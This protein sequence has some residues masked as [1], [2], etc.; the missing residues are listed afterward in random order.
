MSISTK[1][2]SDQMLARFSQISEEIQLRQT[3]ISTG[4]E[5]TEAAEK[6]LEAVKLSALE[7]GLTQLGG[8][9]KNVGVAQSRLS[10][11]DSVL[12]SVDEYFVRLRE[13]S[14]S[15][16]NDTKSASDKVALKIEVSSIREALIGLANTQTSGGEALF[17][18]YATDIVPF[19][20]DSNGLIK[21]RG[22]G[23]QHT[24]AAS[25][26]MRLP[27]SIN[28]GR[29]FMNVETVDG[30]ASIFDIVDSFEAALATDASTN[31][32]LSSEAGKGLSLS[33]NGD[34]T[35]RDLSFTLEGTGGSKLITASEVVGGSNVRLIEAINNHTVNTG[36]AATSVDG[37]LVL[38][39][40]NN[41]KIELSNLDIE[42]VTLASRTPQFTITTNDVPSKTMVP[43]VQSLSVHLDKIIK[44]GE[45]IAISRTTVGARLQ[46]ANDQET[47]IRT[48]SVAFEADVNEL[49]S[50]DLEKTIV[51]MNTLMLMRDVA[52]QAYSRI[53]QTSLF[54]F[55][56]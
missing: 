30:I 2:S 55:M 17:G 38:S 37:R 20:E 3:K 31:G 7:E 48:R 19:S 46:R 40:S 50:A 35:P 27:T 43:V 47:A 25:E 36:I 23:G 15:A 41:G 22:D 29:A 18:G 10:L 11:G 14:V 33:F 1:L 44:A 24:L 26:T 56:K 9:E 49:A 51:E 34:R 39:D 13:I 32:T 4:R 5:I 45:D 42:G 53:S 28:G 21:Y 54:D 52:R 12:K 6:P 16:N 8:F